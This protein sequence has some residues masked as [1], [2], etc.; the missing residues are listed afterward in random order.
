[1][2][3]LWREAGSLN[4]LFIIAGCCAVVSSVVNVIMADLLGRVF[5]PILAGKPFGQILPLLKLTLIVGLVHLV[6]IFGRKFLGSQFS[7]RLQARIR[8]RV[9]ERLAHATATATGGEHSGEIVS[10]MSSDMVLMD[11]LL[12]SD[13]LQFTVQTLTAVLAALYMLT[14]SWFLTL[15]SIAPTPFLLLMSNKLTKPLGPLSSAAQADLA[16]ASVLAQETVAGAE[17]SHALSMSGVL[18]VRY[19]N[20]LASWKNHAL[21]SC[22]Q[23][24]KLYS[25]GTVLSMLPFII[26]F[27]VGGFMVLS[28]RLQAGMLITFIQLINYLAFPLQEM[29][30]LM[31]Q[32]RSEAAAAGRVLELLDLPV[33]RSGGTIGAMDV[34]PLIAFDHVTFSY[35]GSG[36]AQLQDVSFEVHPGQKIALVGTSG[37]GKS[38]ITR[39]LAGD[40]APDQGTIEV[41][42]RRTTAWS[43]PSLRQHIAVVDQDAFLFNDTIAGNVHL[44]SLTAASQEVASALETARADVEQSFPEEGA[45]TMVGEA[46]GR[47]SGGQRQRI[48]L[49]RAFI[50]DAPILILDEATSALDNELERS[51]YA[52]MLQRYPDKTIIAVAHRLTTIKDSDIIYV[53]DGGHIVE[54]GTHDELLAA[55]GRYAELW[56]LQQSKE[57]THE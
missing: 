14:H 51:V 50:K 2:K 32:I 45:E 55:Q 56:N 36:A 20:R 6:V 30:R 8:N 41:G 29:P 11:Q 5:S 38:T 43:L 33:E 28:G 34:D 4:C 31:G 46:A 54:Q 16:S 13:A 48:A 1:M 44:G 42:G 15:V 24:S 9:A 40:Y 39:L 26:I 25:S 53:F 3:R 52:R 22:R 27:S 23:V 49:A 17:V 37:S 10:R 57:E 18:S 47:I 35:P 7:E 19:E 12:K 21:Q